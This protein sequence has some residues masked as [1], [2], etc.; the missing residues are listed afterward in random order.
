MQGDDM[1]LWALV[2][3]DNPREEREIALVGTGKPAPEGKLEY[4]STIQ[5]YGNSLVIHV[6]EVKC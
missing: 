6:M 2:D 1:C 5:L 4:I 3:I